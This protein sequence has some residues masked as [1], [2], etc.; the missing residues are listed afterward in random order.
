MADR[1]KVDELVIELTARNK[2]TQKI[3]NLAKSLRGLGDSLTTGLS[4][5][6]INSVANSL[7][8]ISTATQEFGRSTRA[9]NNL[10]KLTTE[11]SNMMNTLHD[12]PSIS[13]DVLSLAHALSK[14]DGSAI[15]GFSN[16][17]NKKVNTESTTQEMKAVEQEAVKVDSQTK[18]VTQTVNKFGTAIK[19][20]LKGVPS[21]LKKVSDIDFGKLNK[22]LNSI[23]GKVGK[24]AGGVKKLHDRV[25]LTHKLQ[26]MS[27]KKGFTTLLRYTVGIRSLFVLANKIRGAIEDGNKN[28]AKYSAEFNT[29]M[30]R[31]KSGLGTMKNA[32]SVAFAP[33]V[34]YFS[35]A[36]NKILDSFINAFNTIARLMARLTGAKQVV[37]ATRYYEDFADSLGSASKNAKNLTTGID[38]LNILNEQS[39]SGSGGS[40]TDVQDM[41]ETVDVTSEFDDWIKNL[42]SMWDK[43]DFT[44]FGTAVA[45]KINGALQ[46]IDWKTIKGNA[47]KVGKSLATFLNG[48]FEEELN[49]QTFGYTIGKT[50]GEAIN[51]GIEFSYAFV[52]NFH[53]DSFGQ[54]IA[55]GIKGAL[56]TIE[57]KKWGQT[58]SRLVNGVLTTLITLF[59]DEKLWN[60]LGKA[61]GQ[62]FSGINWKETWFNLKALAKAIAKAIKSA[63]LSWAKE[64]PESFGIATAIGVSIGAIK[65]ATLAKA[66]SG[67]TLAKKM[68][69][70]MTTSVE[71]AGGAVVTAKS[72]FGKVGGFLFDAGVSALFT[73]DLMA[74]IEGRK[75]NGLLG[76]LTARPISVQVEFE[77]KS[78]EVF[79][80]NTDEL[81]LGLANLGI[82]AQ[83]S[84][85][86]LEQ[87]L[88]SG[89]LKI[90][91]F[92]EKAENTRKKI[93]AYRGA[94]EIV[95]TSLGTFKDA[96]TQL[97]FD[98]IFGHIF[99]KL[100]ITPLNDFLD[101]AKNGFQT[102]K[103]KI[104]ESIQNATDIIKGNLD[105]QSRDTSNATQNITDAWSN[106]RLKLGETWNLL[107]QNGNKSFDTL[108]RN[109][110]QQTNA[111]TT[112]TKTEWNNTETGLSKIFDFIKQNN[113]T[114]FDTM[115]RGDV[116][117][118]KQTKSGIKQ[119]VQAIVNGMYDLADSVTDSFN[120]QAEAI[121]NLTKFSWTNPI[122]KESFS[123]AGTAIG[124]I[125]KL[126]RMAI[127][128]F[129]NGGII[130]NTNTGSLFWAGENGAEVVAHASGGTEVLNAS[131][132]ASAVASGIREVVIDAVVP[133]LNDLVN[134]NQA[135]ADKDMSVNIGDREIAEAN[136][137]GESSLGLQ[138]VT[139]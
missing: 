75:S 78:Y 23:L 117:A 108:K 135:I 45:D 5:A 86:Q 89:S 62:F 26:N 69:E 79:A 65:V 46:K 76:D 48:V 30:S 81:V 27:L 121:N 100:D 68:G 85:K 4:S 115:Q 32:L 127:P 17:A 129:A 101:N 41:F 134:S 120:K 49:G 39:G 14:I 50:I 66:F 96:L 56:E 73:E 116:E 34:N 10:P 31:Y 90:A 2:A 63:L 132:V 54:A 77:G 16:L 99:D 20:A 97:G 11:L 38:E 47:S 18:E 61:I 130:P 133:Y 84:N 123:S 94:F 19:T 118:M 8:N 128:Q 6:K 131:Q 70:A 111:T 139:V 55:D 109:T 83:V 137:R 125:A 53:W 107:T 12:A 102:A 40:S 136:R 71:G 3:D 113:L 9:I 59:S 21:T 88:E 58:L 95:K 105:T 106:T 126:G 36:V 91:S 52:T 124:T 42:K 33:L 138:L 114:A 103:D 37:Q 25:S 98:E 87:A 110:T 104:S 35:E 43:A 122:T 64:D 28:L 80:K 119:P 29:S 13:R 44:D 72:V 82:T 92:G 67:A 15:K 57:W 93:E 22:N 60:D 51:T 24:L 1:D 112:A 7:K 74:F